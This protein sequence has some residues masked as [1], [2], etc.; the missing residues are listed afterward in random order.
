[1]AERQTKIDVKKLFRESPKTPVRLDVQD[2]K[3]FVYDMSR[4]IKC[5][6]CTWVDHTYMPGAQFRT[7]CPT[8]TR[9]LFDS[10]GA[11]GKMRIGLALAEGKLKWT[12]K[13]LEIVYA[14][15]LCGACDTGCKR[16]LDLEIGL[17]L[18]AL[19][20]KAVQDGAGPLPAHKQIVQ[21]IEKHHNSFGAPHENRTTWLSEGKITP[22][23]K[24]DLLYFVGCSASYV[25]T[26]IA[27]ATAK[28]LKA[29]G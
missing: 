26:E 17:T 23:K 22:A 1:M 27:L 18:E 5:K 12:D 20:V 9:Y 4:C 24:A 15:P 29:A 10:Y 21:N 8:A 13:L 7:K 14:D 25:N 19:R 6:G 28:I 2:L 16:N 3:N 11:Y